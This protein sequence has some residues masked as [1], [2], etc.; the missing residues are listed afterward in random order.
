MN[1]EKC[2]ICD[3]QEDSD[4]IHLLFWGTS[5]IYILVCDDCVIKLFEFEKKRKK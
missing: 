1:I 2:K 3:K 5:K 4:Y